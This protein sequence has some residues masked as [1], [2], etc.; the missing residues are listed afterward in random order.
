MNIST[1]GTEAQDPQVFIVGDEFVAGQQGNAELDLLL[2]HKTVLCGDVALRGDDGYEIAPDYCG[3]EALTAPILE[4][5]GVFPLVL[6]TAHKGKKPKEGF[7]PEH[8]AVFAFGEQQYL[9]RPQQSASAALACALWF[10]L[11]DKSPLID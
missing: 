5:L 9:T 6:E 11:A 4:G 1:S 2:G 8:V 10:C 3:E 7:A